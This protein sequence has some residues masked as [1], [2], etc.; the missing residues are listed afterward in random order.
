[1]LSPWAWL[2]VGAMVLSLFGGT[3]YKGVQS[4]KA[5]VQAEWDQDKDVRKIAEQAA[6]A[7]RLRD[8]EAIAAKAASDKLK[9]KKAYSDEISKLRADGANNP[10]L[11][12]N[13]ADC[14]GPAGGR[15]TSGAG[16]GNA[17]TS[18]GGFLPPAVNSNLFALMQQADEI[19]AGC[20]VG[21]EFIKS[22]GMAP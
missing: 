9:Q 2:A 11:P 1:M 17:D 16:R 15:E 18:G 14:V 5:S 6:V 12:I 22:Q 4:G 3:Y 7:G 13:A 21:Q 8:N 20:R 10:R 19:V